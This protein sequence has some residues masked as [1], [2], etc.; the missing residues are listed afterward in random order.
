VTYVTDHAVLRWLERVYGVDIEAVRQQMMTPGLAAAPAIG[1]DTIV[2]SNGARLKLTGDVVST[3]ICKRRKRHR[4]RQR[5][6]SAE[7][8]GLPELSAGRS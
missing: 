4:R 5:E 6:L 3:V 7:E 8:A 2:M 1:C